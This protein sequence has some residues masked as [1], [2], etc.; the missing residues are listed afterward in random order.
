MGSLYSPKN[1]LAVPFGLQDGFCEYVYYFSNEAFNS[2]SAAWTRFVPVS[3]VYGLQIF[4]VH[5]NHL[6]SIMRYLNKGV[7]VYL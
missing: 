2:S 7:D 6:V 3:P 1:H 4:E 5:N